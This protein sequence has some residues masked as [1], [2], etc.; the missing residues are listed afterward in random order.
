LQEFDY[1]D[2]CFTH[3]LIAIWFLILIRKKRITFA[4]S[5]FFLG[6]LPKEE[7][8]F[9]RMQEIQI[10]KEQTKLEN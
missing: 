6:L 7:L 1:N 4:G 8:P 9:K 3:A 10:E 5:M 2:A